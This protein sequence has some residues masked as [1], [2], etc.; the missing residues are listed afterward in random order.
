VPRGQVDARV[1]WMFENLEVVAFYADPS[2]ALDDEG[3]R[4]WDGIIDGWHQ[5]HSH[6]ID[7][8]LWAV[9]TGDNR[10]AFLWDMTS[11]ERTQLFTQAAERFV[12]DV[13]ERAVA[14]ATDGLLRQHLTQRTPP[15]EPVRRL[16]RQGAPRVQ[17]QGRPGGVR[18]R[19]AD[20]AP[21]RAQPACV[22]QTE[23]RRSRVHVMRRRAWRSSPPMR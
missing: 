11:P 17:P 9:R 19:R 21:D 20:A 22:H 8:K 3:E 12:T 18:G 4:F 13:E 10:S 1:D 15:A 7:P 2:H 23:D 16:A 14:F 6:K 5:R